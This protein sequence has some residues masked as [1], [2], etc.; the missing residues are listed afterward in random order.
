MEPIKP[1]AAAPK[2]AVINAMHQPFW[3]VLASSTNVL[4]SGCGGGYDFFRYR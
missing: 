2:A 1:P 3:D 4:I